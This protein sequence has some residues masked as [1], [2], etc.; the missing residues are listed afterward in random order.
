HVQVRNL[1]MVGRYNS[2][3]SSRKIRIAESLG[4]WDYIAHS[5]QQAA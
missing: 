1:F 5:C 2:G 3:A 4:I